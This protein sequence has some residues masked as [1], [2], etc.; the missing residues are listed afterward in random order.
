MAGG[1]KETINGGAREAEKFLREKIIGMV[2]PRA[3][4]WPFSARALVT[5]GEVL[6]KSI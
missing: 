2:E 6:N 5:N 3:N 4:L 1:L